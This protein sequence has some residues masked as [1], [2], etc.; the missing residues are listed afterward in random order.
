MSV[1]A[2]FRKDTGQWYFSLH[3]EE[4]VK[5]HGRRIKRVCLEARSKRAALKAGA[6][7]RTELMA[8]LNV[9]KLTDSRKFLPDGRAI[10]KPSDK[11]SSFVND[12]YLPE[13]RITKKESSVKSDKWR[14]QAL[15]AYFGDYQL[16]EIDP[17]LCFAF[18]QHRKQRINQYKKLE[19][20]ASVNRVIELLKAIFTVAVNYEVLIKNPASKLKQLREESRQRIMSY[21]EEQRLSAVL[22][23]GRKSLRFCILLAINAGL[24]KGEILR[25]R[26]KDF[27]FEQDR[28][29]VASGKTGSRFAGLNENICIALAEYVDLTQLEDETMIFGGVDWIKDTFPFACEQAG[30]EGLRF[31]DLRATHAVRMCEGG[32]NA[33][34]VQQSL[35][36]T[37]MDMS[38]R[39]TRLSSKS[40]LEALN[41]SFQIGDLSRSC[42][43]KKMVA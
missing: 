21:E 17:V 40:M 1:T 8:R 35:G 15:M 39:Y 30:I 34:Y 38:L 19:S 7:L 27:L 32:H 6:V 16:N 42:P 10:P 36:H 33:F 41:N 11:F 28:I 2:F 3:D 29:F 20:N 26:K 43:A 18:Q 14:C 12:F 5:L 25:L 22:H 9:P 4:F 37:T 24:R 23:S 31:H 13:A